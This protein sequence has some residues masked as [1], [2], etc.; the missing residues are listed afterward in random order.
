MASHMHT[1]LIT[2]RVEYH[3]DGYWAISSKDLPG[4]MLAGRDIGPLVE[5]VPAAI[6]LLY[7]LNYQMDVEVTPVE[8]D[9]VNAE[10]VAS[11][12]R[13]LPHAFAALRAA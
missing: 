11:G 10:R 9:G 5:D 13:Q 8:D 4:L 2:I 12:F 6:K 1:T 7:K 3:P